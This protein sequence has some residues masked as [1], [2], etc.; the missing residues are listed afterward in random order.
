MPIT[1]MVGVFLSKVGHAFDANK[2]VWDIIDPWSDF[3]D[4]YHQDTQYNNSCPS[5][6]SNMLAEDVDDV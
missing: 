1:K 5:L 6:P 2:T 4:G 3:H